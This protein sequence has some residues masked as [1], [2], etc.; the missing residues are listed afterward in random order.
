MKGK[1]KVLRQKALALLRSAR[2]F[3]KLLAV[4]AQ[5]GLVGEQRNALVIFVVAVSRLLSKPLNLFV[6]GQSSSG[7]N[8]T[9]KKVLGLIPPEHICEIT[10][11]SD[12]AWDYMGKQLRHKLVFFQ[13]ESV[14]FGGRQHPARL[15]IS[16]GRLERIVTVHKG[17]GQKG[18]TTK[19]QVTEGPVAC[20][21]T[22][23][24]DQL[25]V[26]D[27][28]RHLSVWADESAAQTERIVR[29]QLSAVQ[30]LPEAEIGIWHAVQELL[31]ERSAVPVK[32]PTWFN[33]V[34]K[35]LWTGDVRVR[36][37][38]PAFIEACKTICLIRSFLKEEEDPTELILQFRDYAIATLIFAEAFSK[39]LYS[40]S[41][42]SMEVRECISRIS[43]KN[44]NQPVSAQ[45]VANELGLELHEAYQR[46]REAVREKA[47]IQVN[48]PQ[49]GNKKFFM[50]ATQG[51]EFLPDPEDIFRKIAPAGKRINF[52]HPI[53]GE[54]VIY[55]S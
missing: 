25:Q 9:V 5:E 52:I 8:H 49:K 12:S 40:I 11:S 45:D 13:E 55:E 1:K 34:I 36:R 30:P 38:F 14:A 15:L 35:N 32:I 28:T 21:S 43:S 16:K 3:C 42:K 17:K 46:I 10:N 48:R 4:L 22:T 20:I 41:E 53:T 54:V 47:V 26:D 51:V 19:K 7:K 37:Y 23:T 44:G 2:F 33:T 18:H 27:E 39:S 50:P 31:V 6:K 29:A 24:K